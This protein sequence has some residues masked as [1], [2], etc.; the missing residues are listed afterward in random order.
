MDGQLRRAALVSG[1]L[2]LLFILIGLAGPARDRTAERTTQ[3]E[4]YADGPS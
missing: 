1:G 3:G 2:I 4:S